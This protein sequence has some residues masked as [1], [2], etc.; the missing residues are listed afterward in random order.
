MY[1]NVLSRSHVARVLERGSITG[2]PT[3]FNLERFGM[4]V[5]LLNFGSRKIDHDQM[6]A[7]KINRGEK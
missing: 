1:T 4:S 2:V 6:S 7:G 5:Y 3:E